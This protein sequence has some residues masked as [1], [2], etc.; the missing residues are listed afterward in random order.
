MLDSFDPVFVSAKYRLRLIKCE[1]NVQNKFLDEEEVRVME[2]SLRK[3]RKWDERN[4]K[5][6]K[7]PLQDVSCSR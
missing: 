7:Q 4:V 1:L 3:E 2:E 5:G 6:A